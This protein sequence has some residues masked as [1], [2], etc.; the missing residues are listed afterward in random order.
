MK[1]PLLSLS[2]AIGAFLVAT[3]AYACSCMMSTPAEHYE[4]AEVVFSG[5]VT[6][7]SEPDRN[8]I[9]GYTFDVDQ[10]W[11]GD[12]GSSVLILSHQDSATC[13]FN[14]SEGGEYVVFAYTRDGTTSS[15]YNN[16]L[17][18][19]LCTGTASIRNATETL[20]YLKTLPQSSSSSSSST[21][22]DEC[23]PYVCM[24]GTTHPSCTED[25]HVIN[26]F[27][28]PCLTH[29]GEV[30]AERPFKDIQ[31]DHPLV[32]AITFVKNQ[33]IVEGYADGTFRPE[34][35]ITRAEFVKMLVGAMY[36]G[37]YS[38]ECLNNNRDLLF[39]D[40]SRKEWYAAYVCVAKEENIIRGYPD[41]SFRPSATIN[42]A[43]AA[44]IVALTMGLDVKTQAGVEWYVPYINALNEQQVMP[45]GVSA[46]TMITRGDMAEILWNLRVT[47]EPWLQ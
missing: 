41:G 27:A 46:G 28:P 13:G 26:Y 36:S 2:T 42:A 20:A 31:E 24:D 23:K 1:H 19:G 22:S 44:K 21:I 11:K 25:G 17:W 18:T 15:S 34:R 10:E 6:A 43:E 39:S 30:S 29:G 45:A 3:T 14:F 35:L 47:I 12:V 40:V 37:D 9:I 8:R 33:R 38:Y 7:V 32:D 5:T 4:R 16:E